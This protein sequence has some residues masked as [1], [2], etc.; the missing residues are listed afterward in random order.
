MAARIMGIYTTPEGVAVSLLS[1][2]KGEK[3]RH[4]SWH[5]SFL[6]PD[7]SRLYPAEELHKLVHS[8]TP[9]TTVL[10]DVDSPVI[11]LPV[12]LPK[13]KSS[14]VFQALKI[15]F[16][17]RSIDEMMDPMVGFCPG[18][19]GATKR[20]RTSG[21]SGFGLVMASDAL[22]E[23]EA[24]HRPLGISPSLVSLPIFPLAFS[25]LGL[26]RGGPALIYLIE[27][28]LIM[29]AIVRD[30]GIEGLEVFYG[31]EA[32]LT[33]R[34]G[35]HLTGHPAT[36]IYGFKVRGGKEPHVEPLNSLNALFV[37][38]DTDQE[39]G[40]VIQQSQ[41][42]SRQTL[43][44]L[45]AHLPFQVG[46]SGFGGVPVEVPAA[47]ASRMDKGLLFAGA[48]LV[49]LFLGAGAVAGLMA[50][51]DRQIYRAQKRAITRLV[52]EVVPHAPPLAALTVVEAQM[53]K[54][55]RLRRH[56]SPM[57]GASTLTLPA[58]VLP[59]LDKTGRVHILELSVSQG[60]FEAVFESAK[61]VETEKL[62]QR[63]ADKTG[64][65]A[66]VALAQK[67]SASETSAGNVY[68]ISLKARERKE[69]SHAQ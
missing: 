24:K 1:G 53:E 10:F 68:R 50:R 3:V 42:I 51:A 58:E 31:E 63:L 7:G 48:L 12:S 59:A 15:E 30:E 27:G 6:Q 23:L 47:K 34:L 38:I 29:L 69:H 36:K 22:R 39:I 61:P 52:K 13:L 32:A 11:P 62:K 54:V 44:V 8:L 41:P 18:T 21:L 64:M 16:A 66:E 57:L 49:L 45:L 40:R 9:D 19:P 35:R 65:E 43:A 14:Q 46:A 26:R 28:S 2:V 20:K 55:K 17:S 5:P 4:V 25:Y 67:G 33:D 60:I 37:P 56:L